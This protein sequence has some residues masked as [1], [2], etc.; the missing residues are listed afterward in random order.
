VDEVAY[1]P[2]ALMLYVYSVADFD[3]VDRVALICAVMDDFPELRPRKCGPRDPPRIKVTTM[4]AALVQVERPFWYLLVR[5]AEPT[6]E[7]GELDIGRGRGGYLSTRAGNDAANF[8]LVPHKFNLSYDR[9]WFDAPHRYVMVAE[10]FRRMCEAMDAFYGFACSEA[11]WL[12][13]RACM[14]SGRAGL[15]AQVDRELPDVMW[16]N[17]FGPSWLKRTDH[18]LGLGY[19]QTR[20]R[21]GGVVL[22][23]T[24]KPFVFERD[25]HPM[26]GYPWKQPLIDALGKDT[27]KWS[28]QV[29]AAS[30]HLVPSWE[31]HFAASPGTN[32]MPWANWKGDEAERKRAAREKTF[33]RKARA[34]EQLV[35]DRVTTPP[36]RGH[37]EFST[38]FDAADFRRFFQALAKR[39]GGDLAGKLGI[40]LLAEIASAP[41]DTD[42]SYMLQVAT[43]GQDE[44][45]EFEY[46]T[47]DIDQVDVCLFGSRIFHRE[48]L[49]AF[50]TL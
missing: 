47:D 7:G 46:F 41:L 48:C 30:G 15:F 42:R 40:V 33:P 11:L 4:G 22:Q 27:F 18:M 26:L 12:A 19:D 17:Y 25:A 50:E 23:T 29:Q 20:T 45:I 37:E 8:T 13:R 14:P 43:D 24:E 28:E 10:F 49:A 35:R 6:Y 16:L 3:A 44:L 9:H 34:A 36:V 32:E 2:D 21:N 1:G 38:N 31:E 5:A 39:V